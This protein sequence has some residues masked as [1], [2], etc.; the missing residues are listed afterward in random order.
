METGAYRFA[1]LENNDQLVA[2]IAELEARLQ[3]ELGKDIT[4]IAYTKGE[5]AGVQTE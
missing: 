2:E 5:P 4:L 1:D 3:R